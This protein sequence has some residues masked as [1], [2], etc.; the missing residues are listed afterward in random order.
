M[1]DIQPVQVFPPFVPANTQNTTINTDRFK[2]DS[3]VATE[4]RVGNLEFKDGYLIGLDIATELDEAIKVDQIAGNARPGGPDLSVQY[5]NN[6]FAGKSM[7]RYEDPQLI[8]ENVLRMKDSQLVVN[9]PFNRIRNVDDPDGPTDAATKQFTDTLT[10][11]L[12]LTTINNNNG[13]T[14]PTSSIYGLIV[15]NSVGSSNNSVTDITPTAAQIIANYSGLKEVNV[16]FDFYLVNDNINIYHT[17][18]GSNPYPQYDLFTVSFVGGTGVIIYPSSDFIVPRTHVLHA[19]C[20]LTNVTSG[21]EAVIIV[22]NSIGWPQITPFFSPVDFN[23]FSLLPGHFSPLPTVKTGVT[24]KVNQLLSNIPI[25][26]ISDIDYVYTPEDVARGVVF[27][28]PASASNDKIDANMCILLQNQL[29]KIVNKGNG[30]ISIGED[31]YDIRPFPL[32]I[33]SNTTSTLMIRTQSQLS[34]GPYESNVIQ[35]TNPGFSYTLGPAEIQHNNITYMTIEI[36]SLETI[37]V[38]TYTIPQQIDNLPISE[39]EKTSLKQ[40]LSEEIPLTPVEVGLRT[41][42]FSGNTSLSVYVYGT[43]PVGPGQYNV[44]MQCFIDPDMASLFPDEPTLYRV[45]QNINPD[46]LYYFV[47]LT[48][49]NS[50]GKFRI[51]DYG[52][53]DIPNEA[54]FSIVQG[55]NQT[56]K[57]AINLP[58]ATIIEVSK[59]S[60]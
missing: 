59:S 45:Q 29:F 13:V 25:S 10:T 33:E 19:T 51:T 28:N 16:S 17:S 4:T 34:L 12:E 27:R 24:A 42:P 36:D 47:A 2:S 3:I 56:S 44:Y 5:N 35:L 1:S 26:W 32:T 55:A 60:N 37:V 23:Y 31:N 21:L 43:S 8:V 46:S 57:C 54:E 6:E 52:I 14:W 9:A 30:D 41:Y 53:G 20:V 7:L 22:I 18:G 40:Y 49:K 39:G 38:P 11:G 15:R 58:L 48:G 50:P